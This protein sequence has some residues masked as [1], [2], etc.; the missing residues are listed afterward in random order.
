M[1]SIVI[2]SLSLGC[3]GKIPDRSPMFVPES[4]DVPEGLHADLF[5]LRPL[6]IEDAEAD[7][8][9]VMESKVRLRKIFGGDWPADDF[10]L[11]Q[12]KV[13][14]EHH[15]SAHRDRSAFTYTIISLEDARIL[16]CLYIF[17]GEKTGANV[18]FWVRESAVEEGL[19]PVVRDTI[20]RWISEVWPFHEVEIMHSLV[21]EG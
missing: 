12:N 16:G 4:F 11:E 6:S 9:A 13:D 15:M 18:L 7:Y 2:C 19:E 17:P 20:Q 14:L 8:E 1:I 3:S 5:Y 10:T 21:Q